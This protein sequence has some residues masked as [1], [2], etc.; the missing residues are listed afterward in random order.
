MQ[1]FNAAAIAAFI[2]AA[3]GTSAHA[4]LVAFWNFNANAAS[5]SVATTPIAAAYT[6]V[7]TGQMVNDNVVAT[8]LLLFTPSGA[9]DHGGLNGLGAYG[10]VRGNDLAVQNGTG[11]INNGKS[12]TF[13]FN[14]TD[15][16]DLILTFAGRRTST[17]FSELAF[18]VSTDGTTFTPSGSVTTT[19]LTTSYA[20]QT[21]NLAAAANGASNLYL[22][23]TLN[24]TGTSAAGN[25]R[26]DNLQVNGTLIPAPG[27]AAL[28]GVATLVGLR[29]RR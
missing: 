2:A 9:S 6:A 14:A 3:A 17:G 10:D 1:S 12:V 28:L 23:M 22:R 15:F 13:Q 11:G 19:T 20:L 8:N 25:I 27:A 18:S 5:G 21:V 29:R 7:G 26:I 24:G 16:T 4:D